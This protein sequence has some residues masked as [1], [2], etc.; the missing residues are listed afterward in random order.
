[1]LVSA[2]Q[3]RAS[4]VSVLVGPHLSWIGTRTSVST[5]IITQSASRAPVSRNGFKTRPERKQTPSQTQPKPQNKTMDKH[6]N[7]ETNG[8]MHASTSQKQQVWRPR[9]ESKVE[10][11]GS[12]G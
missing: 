4:L 8:H 6:Q 3:N 7:V 1:M 5:P 2:N 12:D 10:Q 9:S 11:N